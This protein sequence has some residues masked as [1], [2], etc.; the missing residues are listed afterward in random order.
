MGGFFDVVSFTQEFIVL[1]TLTTESR[2]HT[3]HGYLSRCKEAFPWSCSVDFFETL[4][5]GRFLIDDER[6]SEILKFES[7]FFPV[8]GISAGPLEQALAC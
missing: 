8:F 1:E 4:A 5:Q 2:H 6:F 7:C 3:N